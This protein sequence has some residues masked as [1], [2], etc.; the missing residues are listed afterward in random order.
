MSI[1]I[2]L[3]LILSAFFLA[4]YHADSQQPTIAYACVSGEPPLFGDHKEFYTRQVSPENYESS[5]ASHLITQDDV[6]VTDPMDT[7]EL[8]EVSLGELFA[9]ADEIIP[10]NAAVAEELQATEAEIDR[11]YVETEVAAVDRVIK[12]S[13]LSCRRTKAATVVQLR[14]IAKSLSKDPVKGNKAQLTELV[15]NAFADRGIDEEYTLD[16]VEFMRSNDDLSILV[17][18]K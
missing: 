3:D 1:E 2:I 5:D 6:W 8:E 10:M 17:V 15:L 11:F 4:I 14:A 9:M 12:L 7:G 13:H 16:G 18:L